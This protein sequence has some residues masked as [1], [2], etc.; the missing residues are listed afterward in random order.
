MPV[1][2]VAR[3]PLGGESRGETAQSAGRLPLGKHIDGQVLD[4]GVYKCADV[5]CILN[6]LLGRIHTVQMLDDGALKPLNCL[7]A[8]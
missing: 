6:V 7:H 3:H 5:V 4:A 2:E 8:S 1:N